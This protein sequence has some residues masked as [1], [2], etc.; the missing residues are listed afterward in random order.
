[1]SLVRQK[2]ILRIR[3]VPPD[4]SGWMVTLS[5]MLL[6]LL[7]FFVLLIAMSSFD[8]GLLNEIFGTRPGLSGV[9]DRGTS[10]P[11]IVPAEEL[12]KDP[13]ERKDLAFY[14][15]LSKP[16]SRLLDVFERR[17][18]KALLRADL[19]DGNLELEI[20]SDELFG[21][22]DD[23][24]KPQGEEVLR[25]FGDFLKLWNGVLEIEVYTDNFPLQTARFTDNNVLAAWR[26]ERLT[27]VLEKSGF[28]RSQILLAAYGAD[29]AVAVND[30][31]RHR[32]RNRRIVFRLPGWVQ[33]VE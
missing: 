32:W 6:L 25:Q 12:R 24:L 30:T 26:G 21:T 15:R 17:L 22:L 23:T 13:R 20:V 19:I 31:P 8:Q 4:S 2:K 7:T 14:R 3:P 18:G 33:T 11:L 9:L 1:M 10:I 27:A 5:D 28:K 16:L 29:H